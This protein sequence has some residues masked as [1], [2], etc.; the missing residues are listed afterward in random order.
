MR[1]LL[2]VD[3]AGELAG[4]K[5]PVMIVSGG[6]DLQVTAADAAL[7]AKARPDAARLDV[8]GMNHVLKIAPPDLAGQ[9]DAYANTSLPLAPGLTDAVADFARRV[10]R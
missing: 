5:L 7:L 6:H 10:V 4:L 9:R 2:A 8:P 1:S 3:P